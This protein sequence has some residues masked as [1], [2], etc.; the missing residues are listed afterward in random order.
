MLK[1]PRY[2]IKHLVSFLALETWCKWPK[3]IESVKKKWFPKF[4]QG[5]SQDPTTRCIWFGIATTHDFDIH[6]QQKFGVNQPNGNN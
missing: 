3:V 5:L 4:S 2:C 6:M 1:L